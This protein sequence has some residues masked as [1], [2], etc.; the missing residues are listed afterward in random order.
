MRYMSE[1]DIQ[2]FMATI[3]PGRYPGHEESWS[4][5]GAA[6]QVW[7]AVGKEWKRKGGKYLVDVAVAK[8]GP[9]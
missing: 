7:A 3:D 8:P 1:E 9:G 2:G 5:Q 4:G 6:T